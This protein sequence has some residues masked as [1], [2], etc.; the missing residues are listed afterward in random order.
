MPLCDVT[1]L[2]H[3][4]GNVKTFYAN[5]EMRIFISFSDKFHLIINIST[6]L[7][8]DAIINKLG[9][10]NLIY[11]LQ[12]D[13]D[14][15]KFMKLHL[16]KFYLTSLLKLNHFITEFGI[17]I[18]NSEADFAKIAKETQKVHV[19]DL[20]HVASMKFTDNATKVSKPSFM[21]EENKVI[22]DEIFIDHVCNLRYSYKD[23][24]FLG[25][26]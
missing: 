17:K 8:T 5:P 1:S 23:I 19:C 10:C 22:A 21:K 15:L 7:T 6:T 12:K 26:N 3:S 2:F 4:I 9:L 25:T 18:F 20:F 13:S 11:N 16:P 14:Y 24:Y